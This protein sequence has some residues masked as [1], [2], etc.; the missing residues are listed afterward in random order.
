[1]DLEQGAILLRLK[2]ITCT[3][4]NRALSL[5][6]GFSQNAAGKWEESGTIPYEACF[7]A[8]Q[9]TGYST[10]W[11]LTGKLPKKFE[12]EPLDVSDQLI[13]H[14]FQETMKMAYLSNIIPE[15]SPSDMTILSN[16][17]KNILNGRG[18]VATDFSKEDKKKAK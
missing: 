15:I 5:S 3:K 14:A 6:L 1:M 4:S 18:D 10:D 7:K 13:E 17:N 11:I 9:K 2:E 8:A 16:I 12:V